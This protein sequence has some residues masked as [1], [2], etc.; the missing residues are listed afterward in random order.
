MLSSPS[1]VIFRLRTASM[2]LASL[3]MSPVV[4]R[5]ALVLL[6]CP[7]LVCSKQASLRYV[8][9]KQNINARSRV[10]A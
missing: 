2:W 7:V 4:A 6:R 10:Q 3:T 9:R 1:C 5:R 8:S